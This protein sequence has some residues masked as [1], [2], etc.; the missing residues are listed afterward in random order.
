MS[1]K[2][3]L[4]NINNMA[5]TSLLSLLLV[6]GCSSGSSGG[7]NGAV[8]NPEQTAQSSEE[9]LKRLSPQHRANFEA[10]QAKVVKSCDSAEAFG[11]QIDNAIEKQGLDGAALIKKNNGSVIFLDGKSLAVLTGYNTFSG[12]GTTKSEETKDINGQSYTISA[13]T[14]RD[15]SRC[16][17]YLFGQKVYETSVAES[18]IIGAHYSQAKEATVTSQTPEIKGLGASG[19]A[20]V[21]QHGVYLLLS[22]SLRPSAEAQIFIGQ[23]LGLNADQSKNLFRSSDIAYT[24]SAVKM[25]DDSSAIW[26]NSESGNLIS[27]ATSLS[28]AFDGNDRTVSFE[29]RLQ[30]PQFDFGGVKNTT[31]NGNLKLTL[32]SII[33]QKNNGFLYTLKR[34]VSSGIIAF[35]QTEAQSCAKNRF[36]AYLDSSRNINSISPSTYLMFSPCKTIFEDIETV[37]YKNGFLKSLIPDVFENVTPSAQFQYN[38]WDDVL[39]QL[40]LQIVKQNED[41]VSELDPLSKT[42]IVRMIVS[43]LEIIKSEIDQSKNMQ[44]LKDVALQMGLVWSF[45]GNI[46]SSS[47]IVQIIQSLDSSSD[48]FKI[49]SER[50][51]NDLALNPYSNDDQLSFALSID[52][53]FKNE[54]TKALNL[55]KDLSYGLF[56]KEVFNQV[57]QKKV[58]LDELKNWNNRFSTIKTEINKYP[59]LSSY[60]GDLVGSALKWLKNGEVSAQELSTIYAALNNSVDP[61]S[62]STKQLVSDLGLSLG[63][64]KEALEFS[65]HLTAEY[66]KLAIAIR[67]NSAAAEYESWGRSFFRSILQKRPPLAQL[68]QWNDMWASVLSFIQREK[69][70]VAGESGLMPELSRKKVIAVALKEVWSS[71]E[72]A[73]FEAIANVARTKNACDRYKDASSQADCVGLDLF[74]K[75]PKMFFDP[76]YAGRYTTLGS[77]FNRY[78]NQMSD[79]DWTSLKWSLVSEFFGS[80]Q[81]IWSSCDNVIFAQKATLLKRQM[82]ALFKEADQFK[83]WELER[84]IKQTIQNCE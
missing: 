14:K 40:A 13:E 45:N 57:I 56:E 47:R 24:N 37:S 72:F 17:V 60:K 70:R 31:D 51:L 9:A 79:S 49:S 59:A 69:A 64:N 27:N 20:E 71:Q 54:A 35:S 73:A 26:S 12:T 67:N 19:S 58:S 8:P 62:D 3:K 23:S 82:S 34:L 84:Q 29:I 4:F 1:F 55:S 36:A 77:D 78:M 46:V 6:I 39:S 66:K 52:D 80:S 15:G 18:F 48:I 75:E 65:N 21:V 42:K 50:L 7:D 76:T 41:L 43:N 2:V 28:N 38:G 25:S 68:V 44:Q 81:P 33:A 11:L 63:A 10:W 32:S 16:L 61:F 5:K 30:V 53:Q 83:K 22:Q 74:S